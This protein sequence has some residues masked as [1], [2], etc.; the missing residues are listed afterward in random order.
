MKIGFTGSRN[1]MT[2]AQGH[3]LRR[4]VS[5][6]TEFHHGACIGA[7]E[8]AVEGVTEWT[9]AR[10]IAHPGA[11]ALGGDNDFLSQRAIDMS[12]EVRTT[13]THFARNRNIVD[14][15]DVL[16]A[17]PNYSTPITTE[18]KGGTAYTVTYARKR[19]C[20]NIVILPSGETV[21][22]KDVVQA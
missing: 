15:S 18:T 12:G 6:A 2:L 17:T 19:G 16:I 1:G 4:L 22:S 11:S 5:G 14:S 9:T 3:T 20:R 10:I 8:D 7:D 13:K 21:D